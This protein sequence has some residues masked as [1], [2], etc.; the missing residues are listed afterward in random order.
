MKNAKII[1]RDAKTTGI[2]GD[3]HLRAPEV[4]Q[5]MPYGSKADSWSFGVIIYYM[6]TQSLPFTATD[7]ESLEYRIVNT[8]PDYEIL[9][10][11]HYSASCIELLQ[12]LLNK[13]VF[14]RLTMTAV[15]KCL[16]FKKA[17]EVNTFNTAMEKDVNARLKNQASLQ[18]KKDDRDGRLSK[19]YLRQKS[20][21]RKARGARETGAEASPAIGAQANHN[22]PKN[23]EEK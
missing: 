17:R 18:K 8:E 4:I 23:T 22:N 7:T 5:G 1:A 11:L 6:L 12:K 9:K 19:E 2:L 16:W 14:Q 21:A 3:I 10:D 13:N 15:G 20:K